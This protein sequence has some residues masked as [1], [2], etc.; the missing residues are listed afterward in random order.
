MNIETNLLPQLSLDVVFS[1]TENRYSVK[2]LEHYETTYHQFYLYLTANKLT[3]F[4]KTTGFLFIDEHY[5]AEKKI[6]SRSYYTNLRRRISVLFEF[7]AEGVIT[8]KHLNKEIPSL[9]LLQKV[10]DLYVTEQEK[11]NLA[12]KTV[13][14]KSEIMKQFFLF[15][16]SL[17]FSSLEKLSAE[18]I[19]QYLQTKKHYAVS[20]REGLLYTLR[21]ALQ[22]F[23]ASEVCPK[24]LGKLF[25]QIST[26]SEDPVPSCFTLDE[27]KRILSAVDRSTPIGKRDYAVLLL[28]AFLGIR[29]GDIRIFKISCIKWSSEAIEFTQS[30]TGRFLQLPLLP[31]VK[32]AILDY[33]KNGR[34]KMNSDYLFLKHSAPYGPMDEHN[35]FYYILQKYLDGIEL[36]K[37]KHGMHSLRF[38]AAGNMLS[39]GAPITTICNVLGHTYS[40]TTRR[41]LKIDIDNLRKAALEV[42]V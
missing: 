42:D 26:H 12:S 9:D 7:Y 29:A 11:R 18:V 17:K 14:H 13:Q 40:D 5:G 25:P 32:L 23:A 1:L 33:I 34:P 27:L 22:F 16:E 41:Y 37:R 8:S 28:A 10:Y 36:K 15:L 38:S 21:D 24:D 20:T 4:E 35:C 39:N 3:H 2:T 30:K 6:Q 31:E 19:Y